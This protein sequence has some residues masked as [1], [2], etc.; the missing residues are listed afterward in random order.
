[1]SAGVNVDIASKLKHLRQIMCEHGIDAYL[2]PSIDAHNSE[3]VPECWQRRVWISGFDGSA[4]EVLVTLDGAYLW[5]DGRY[6]L[7]AEAQ[8][9]AKC[10]TLMRQSGFVPEL[11]IWLSNNAVGKCLSV[12]P[13]LVSIGRANQLQTIMD[14][15]GG[16]LL[17]LDENLI[18]ACKISS[19]EDVSRPNKTTGFILPETYTGNSI[20][21][22]LNA[23]RLELNKKFVDYIALNVLDEIAWLFNLRGS[24][25]DYN[26]LLISYAIIGLSEAWLFVDDGKLPEDVIDKLK[27]AGITVLHYNQFNLHLQSLNK[28]IWLDDKTA[29][30]SMLSHASRNGTVVF[31]RSPIVFS[32]ACKNSIEQNGTRQAHIK[33]AVA[34]VNF[35]TWLNQAHENSSLNEISCAD[36]LTSFRQQQANLIGASFATIS[37]FAGNG[38]IIHYRASEA[39]CKKVDA[40]DM[41]LLDSGAQYLEGTT[42]ITRTVHLGVPT[43]EQKKN[44]TL[45]LKGH[46]ALARAVFPHGT[47]GEHLDV[48]ARGPLWDEFLDYRHGTGHGVGS[49]LCVHEGPQKISKAAS[50]TPLLPGMIVSNEPG[51]YLDGQYGIRIENLCLVNEVTSHVAQ[52]SQYGKFYQFE[53]LTL[54][55]YCKNLLDMGL[56]TDVEKA[57]IVEYYKDI[58]AKVRPHLAKDVQTWLDSELA[59]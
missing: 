34:I 44:Y 2:V 20:K 29:N 11:P 3:Y 36:K 51:V 17:L 27:S 46:L 48:L 32:K 16:K 8:L 41:Y 54:V 19:G 24:D 40:S 47:H 59:I 39:T 22:K 14:D 53:N 56:I 12:D 25:V 35:L 50:E 23:L 57:Q 7:Q 43:A 9:D 52:N 15:I 33:D 55:P 18:D 42:D 38:A 31:A 4:G 21:N 13:Q 37:G 5:T 58:K 6:F 28:I 30:Q 49:F 1:M 10:Y 45:V 26:P